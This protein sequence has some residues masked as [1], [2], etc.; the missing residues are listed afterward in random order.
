MEIFFPHDQILDG[1]F[2]QNIPLFSVPP[3]NQ[4]IPLK[5]SVHFPITITIYKP[6]QSF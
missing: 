1:K 2:P 6:G 4:K 5:T 3:P